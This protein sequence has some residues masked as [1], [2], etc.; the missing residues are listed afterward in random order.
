MADFT[1]S[2]LSID[3]SSVGSICEE[4]WRAFLKDITVIPTPER[5]DL[6]GFLLNWVAVF[7]PEAFPPSLSNQM[8]AWMD[9]FL[10]NDTSVW[11][12]T[13]PPLIGST[14]FAL[15]DDPHWLRI[16]VENF[17]DGGSTLRNFLHNSLALVA[18]RMSFDPA[19]IARLDFGLKTAYFYMDTPMVLY[20]VSKGD[21][22]TKV[23]NLHKWKDAYFM[24]PTEKDTVAKLVSGGWAENPLQHWLLRMTSY[25]ALRLC[26]QL[27]TLSRNATL[28]LGVDMS[29]IWERID[30]H[31]LFSSHIQLVRPAERISNGY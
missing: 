17:D 27:N 28:P 8:A 7:M 25:V 4:E 29:A 13:K 12:F 6:S 1:S 18:P 24:N 26:C 2:P 14:L 21:P 10:A 15:Y 20:A 19:L 5:Q 30:N 11:G 16:Q 9:N 23:A 3:L 31:P 22:V